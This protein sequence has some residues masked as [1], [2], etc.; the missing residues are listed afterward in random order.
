MSALLIAAIIL[1]AIGDDLVI[2]HP[3]EALPSNELLPL[4]AGPALYLLTL[5]LMRLRSTG[6]LV[7]GRPLAALVIVLVGLV[8]QSASALVVSA[9]VLAVLVALIAWEELDFVRR[10]R[11]GA[12]L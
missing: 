7:P 2:K 11:R 8:A 6:R 4:V 10:R 1:V 9:L 5:A 3:D 12:L